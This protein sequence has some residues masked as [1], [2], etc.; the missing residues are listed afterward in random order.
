VAGALGKGY[1]DRRADEEVRKEGVVSIGASSHEQLA[2]GSDR[3]DSASASPSEARP[4]IGS[5]G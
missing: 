1:V 4:T 2:A 3:A 5:T